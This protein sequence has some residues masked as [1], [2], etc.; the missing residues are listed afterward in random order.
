MRTSAEDRDRAIDIV[1]A[2][3]GEG[4]LTRE[5]LDTRTEQAMS[6]QYYPDLARVIADLP[7]GGAFSGPPPVPAPYPRYYPGTRSATNGLAVASLVSSLFGFFP[8]VPSAAAVVMGHVSLAQMRRD[9][10]RGQGAAFAG[11]VL[12]YLG[13][14]GWLLIFVIAAV[15]TAHGGGPGPAPGP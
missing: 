13:L 2:A 4:R 8:F 14:A 5:E 11:L 15:V 10:Q 1:K 7:G 12:G 6:A 9:P 3:F